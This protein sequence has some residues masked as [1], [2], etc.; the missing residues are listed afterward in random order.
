MTKN[1]CDQCKNEIMDKKYVRVS[2]MGPIST[3]PWFIGDNVYLCEQCY[4]KVKEKMENII[5]NKPQE[6]VTTI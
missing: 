5:G 3:K 2:F 6:A 1:Y 4:W